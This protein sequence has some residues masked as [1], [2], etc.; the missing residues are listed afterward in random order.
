MARQTDVVAAFS[1]EQTSRLTGV[2]MG[3]LR[4]WDRTDFYRPAYAEKNRRLTFSR[5]YSFRDIVALR[6]LNTLRNDLG[7]SLPHLREV[8]HRL[9]FLRDE[10]WTGVKLWVLDKRVV[11]QEPKS[12]IP[13]EVLSGQYVLKPIALE[14]V[15]DSTKASIA[16]MP[17]ARREGSIGRVERKRNVSRNAPVIAGTRIPVATIK[18][19]HDAGYSAEAIIEEYPDLTTQDVRAALVYA[20][21]DRAA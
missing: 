13:Q 8:S 2:S 20:T 21:N 10:R 6:V 1:E 5:I 18:R 4:Y 16:Q 7:V 17:R 15:V 9:S 11:W 12:E 19:F 14:E 3:Q